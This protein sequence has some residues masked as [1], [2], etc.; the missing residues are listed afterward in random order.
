MIS[1]A[2]LALFFA[3][4]ILG[5][6]TPG[7]DIAALK[8][9][10]E[11]GD[12]AAQLELGLAYHD[13]KGVPLNDAMAARWIRKSADQG[14]APAQNE[15]GILYR[16]GE[17]VDRD[18]QESVRWFQF[19]AAQ[20]NA[21]AMFNLGA[22]YYN[23]DGV[24]ISD[25]AAC[26]WFVLAAEFG[27]DKAAEAVSRAERELSLD[28]RRDCY[29]LVGEMFDLGTT[30]KQ[31]LTR[32]LHYYEKA[33]QLGSVSGQVMTATAYLDGRGTAPNPD[34]ARHWSDEAFKSKNAWGAFLKGVMS[35][36]GK[37]RPRDIGDAIKWYKKAAE[38]GL[39]AAMANLAVIYAQP[40]GV[41]QD[42][43][44]AYF[45][46]VLAERSKYEKGKQGRMLIERNLTAAEKAVVEKNVE[47]WAKQHPASA[48]LLLRSRSLSP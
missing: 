4:S 34:L 32:A 1:S 7:P 2:L 41:K 48:P 19:A 11:A 42:Y 3:G 21:K 36:Q 16:L 9:K 45:W 24:E 10:A 33:A 47:K 12:A 13:G 30:I 28:R 43:P 20:W 40:D 22:A 31:D 18:K 14:Y 29:F 6:A 17:G 35:Q 25:D 23:G 44:T 37:G 46:F 27:D 15:L 26:R 5:Q 8:A 39:G 38:A